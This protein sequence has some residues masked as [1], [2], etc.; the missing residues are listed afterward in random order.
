MFCVVN[1]LIYFLIKL[2]FFIA[3]AFAYRRHC[4]GI[5]NLRELI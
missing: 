2:G 3:F 1:L 4:P 5:R